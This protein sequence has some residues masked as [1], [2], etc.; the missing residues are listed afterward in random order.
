[1]TGA[2]KQVWSPYSAS[3]SSRQIQLRRMDLPWPNHLTISIGDVL[4]LN[5]I[6]TNDTDH[7]LYLLIIKSV[8]VIMFHS[9]ITFTVALFLLLLLALSAPQPAATPNPYGPGTGY[10]GVRKIDP[11][12]VDLLLSTLKEDDSGKIPIDKKDRRQDKDTSIKLRITS[13]RS[14]TKEYF[15]DLRQAAN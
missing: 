13:P 6:S 11:R 9:I 1:M 14:E 10:C 12:V 3:K 8:Q 15:R 4:D 2:G 5:S 7:P